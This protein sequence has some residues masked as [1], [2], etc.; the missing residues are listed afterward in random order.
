M[1]PI[2]QKSKHFLF[3]FL[4]AM[5]L[6]D[7]LGQN[8]LYFIQPET[9]NLLKGRIIPDSIYCFTRNRILQNK[10]GVYNELG[11]DTNDN[12]NVLVSFNYS[13]KKPSFQ[14]SIVL[15]DITGS[16][17]DSTLI[18]ICHS[19]HEWPLNRLDEEIYYYYEFDTLGSLAYSTFYSKK[20]RSYNRETFYEKGHPLR[21]ILYQ[22]YKASLEIRYARYVI[23][24]LKKNFTNNPDSIVYFQTAKIIYNAKGKPKNGKVYYYDFF[25]KVCQVDIYRRNRLVKSLKV[26]HDDD[27]SLFWFCETGE[28]Y[29][30]RWKRYV[31]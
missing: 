4:F 31:E 8:A 9:N 5:C 11:Y 22:D 25:G 19:T 17:D 7:V 21:E 23:P 30:R 20:K 18:F 10:V 15:F 27:N 6:V 2:Y 24:P 29:P 14:D 16:L 12:R 1:N 13:F 26:C 3:G 28:P